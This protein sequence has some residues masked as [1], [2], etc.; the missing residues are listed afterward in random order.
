V[1]PRIESRI[2]SCYISSRKSGTRTGFSPSFVCFPL[3]LIFYHCPII[4][5]HCP[6]RCVIPLT[7]QHIITSSISASSLSRKIRCLQDKVVNP[8]FI[9]WF[10]YPNVFNYLFYNCDVTL[11]LK[12]KND[13]VWRKTKSWDAVGH[14]IFRGL[15]Q[16]SKKRLPVTVTGHLPNAPTHN[17]A[18]RQDWYL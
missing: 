3:L 5:R 15:S 7:L 14:D 2:N 18:V 4:I 8:D 13:G 9:Q 10:N 11:G 16:H 17:S 6:V 12:W 1:K